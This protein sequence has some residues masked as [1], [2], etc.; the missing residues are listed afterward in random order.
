MR[1]APLANVAKFLSEF[2]GD[3][4][5]YKPESPELLAMFEEQRAP[6]TQRE[7]D[8]LH[9][10]VMQDAYVTAGAAEYLQEELMRHLMPK[11]NL[12]RYRSWGGVAR[13]VFKFPKT[14]IH[15]RKDVF[16]QN[17]HLLIRDSSFAGRSEC[18][19]TGAVPPCFYMDVSSLYPLCVTSTN[20]LMIKDVEWMTDEELD[21]IRKPSDVYPYAWLA[22]TFETRG[23]D[24][25]W[26]LPMRS[27]ERNYYVTGRVTGFYNSLDL[28]ASH[29][30][31]IGDLDL[32]LKP[33]FRREREMHEKYANYLLKKLK[34]G[35]RSEVERTA[36]K[37]VLNASYGS[38]GMTHPRPSIRS[39]FPAYS[40]VL[41]QS[42]WLMSKIF[43]M[44]PKPIHY[45][46]TDS[47]FV[48]RKTLQGKIMDLTDL[49][50]RI[51]LPLILE[52]KGFGETPK[53]FRSKHYYLNEDNYGFH[54]V[55]ID[56]DDWKRI[57]TT[58]PTADVVRR[59]IRGTL[60]TRSKRAKELQIGRWFTVHLSVTL[61][62]LR[63]IFHADDKRCRE[64]Y[65][66]YD[67]V[68]Q[69]KWIPSRSWTKKEF[70]RHIQKE[71]LKDTFTG[72]PSGIHRNRL[73]LRKWL[74][75]YAREDQGIKCSIE[76]LAG[77]PSLETILLLRKLFKSENLNGG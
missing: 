34:K 52:E 27:G 69:G 10:R 14:N 11:P 67:L 61:D 37:E 1:L 76:W 32:G 36:A 38:L 43:D 46:D 75:E 33:V 65:D 13:K 28:Q 68:R 35:F 55:V 47:I 7:W 50:G 12:Y 53:I 31:I 45:M 62:R 63:T 26:G 39:N 49:E 51:S 42:R 29:A 4:S 54:A 22:G 58:L 40:V 73:F 74:K 57:V 23:P 56:L 59:Q 17:A 2:Y 77:Q 25:L 8:L 30:E 9:E 19:S 16:V 60:L 21:A 41:A 20:A 18:F 48:E 72:L 6:R 44:A 71:E 66:S 64:S 70:T 15:M 24:D 3:P 5:I